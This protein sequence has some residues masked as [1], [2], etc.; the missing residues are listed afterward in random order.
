[1]AYTAELCVRQ[2][3]IQVNLLLLGSRNI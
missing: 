2:K 3:V 1:L